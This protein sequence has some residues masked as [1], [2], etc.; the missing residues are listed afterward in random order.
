MKSLP[1]ILGFL[2]VAVPFAA[3]A[4]QV[5]LDLPV[6]PAHRIVAS[7]AEK[8]G[9]SLKVED[10]FA[11][12]ILFVRVQDVDVEEVLT[13]IAEVTAGRWRTQPD[14]TRILGPDPGA[15][16]R[17]EAE[18]RKK[19]TE[20]LR[21]EMKTFVDETLKQWYKPEIPKYAQGE[22]VFKDDTADDYRSSPS[23]FLLAKCVALLNPTALAALGKGERI[24]YSTTPTKMQ[25]NL[26]VSSAAVAEYLAGYNQITKAAIDAMD[27]M[28]Q[29]PPESEGLSEEEV[30]LI[31]VLFGDD[32]GEPKIQE[33]LPSKVL[34]ILSRSENWEG[35]SRRDAGI[36]VELLV[37][38][39]EGEVVD[40]G[41]QYF[42]SDSRQSDEYLRRE[43]ES[44][45]S[46]EEDVD[47]EEP[48][49]YT[50]R[51]PIVSGPIKYS[52]LSKSLDAFREAR[53][54]PSQ[55]YAEDFEEAL[56]DPEK[57]DLQGFHLEDAL[58]SLSTHASKNILAY[59][60]DGIAENLNYSSDSRVSTTQEFFDYLKAEDLQVIREQGSWMT[61][62]P[63]SLEDA[64]DVRVNR[65][66][67]KKLL[68]I[69]RGGSMPSLDDI[70]GYAATSP[71]FRSQPGVFIHFMAANPNFE[72]IL[73]GRGLDWNVLRAYGL[74]SG[75][76]RDSALQGKP[77]RLSSLTATQRNA[78]R[79]LIYGANFRTK[80][81]REPGPN[82]EVIELFRSLG[83]AERRKAPV[84]YTG[85][86]T[87]ALPWGIPQEATLLLRGV[88][89]SV[90]RIWDKELE[91][92]EFP[93]IGT[94][95]MAFAQ[96]FLE[97][98]NGSDES[99]AK[100]K[101]A[102]ESVYVGARETVHLT[103]QLGDL[104]E[105]KEPLKVDRF[106]REASTNSVAQLPKD[107]LDKIAAAKARLRAHPIMKL[108][109][110]EAKKE[111]PEETGEPTL[112]PLWF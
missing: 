80:P 52:E 43:L 40:T 102:L 14:G 107:Q 21:G 87:E 39:D 24:V 44:E 78:F 111:V 84:S 4:A 36:F 58:R 34:V 57:Y 67:L 95:G 76:Q 106:E 70:A 64:R 46:T 105:V 77:V 5:S 88:E 109:E 85:E 23:S 25:L 2:V 104:V 94:T 47:G 26:T 69:A 99:S 79:T 31:N 65:A 100:L 27:T 68:A 60:Q 96:L 22:E 9:L 62:M 37:L 7:V 17:H 11:K 8:S 72:Q 29:R 30:K 74:L 35:R 91:Y 13:K 63:P 38:N 33:N 83:I 110:R 6:G 90:Y 18:Y 19:R 103:L 82:D 59:L 93:D 108:M 3:R 71:S 86:P 66:A 42:E 101:A 81:L 48:P 32:D 12:D 112:P 20:F 15:L 97:F 54:A 75:H 56:A 55:A 51:F 61:I 41:S 53:G 45:E 1:R 50:P 92:V 28:Q 49:V 16:N 98:S 73:Y 10:H 89:D